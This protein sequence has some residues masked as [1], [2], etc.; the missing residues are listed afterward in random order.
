MSYSYQIL[1]GQIKRKNISLF[2]VHSPPKCLAYLP[3]AKTTQKIDAWICNRP[4]QKLNVRYLEP[5]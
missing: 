5:L 4:L 2:P 3:I 1:L